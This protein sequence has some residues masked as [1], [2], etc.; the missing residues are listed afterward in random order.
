MILFGVFSSGWSGARKVAGASSTVTRSRVSVNGYGPMLLQVHHQVVAVGVVLHYQCSAI[1]DIGDQRI[2][3]VLQRLHR[4]VR[5]DAGDDG[6]IARKVRRGERV[7]GSIVSTIGPSCFK[8]V[9][10]SSPAP[11]M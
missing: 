4:V 3:E 10:T 2:V 5:A 11:L 8:A 1:G 7:A 6:V 9:G